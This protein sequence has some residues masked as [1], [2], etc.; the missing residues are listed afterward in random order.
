MSAIVPE[1]RICTLD[2]QLLQRNEFSMCLMVGIL[3]FFKFVFV[4]ERVTQHYVFTDLV[5]FFIPLLTVVYIFFSQ[6]YP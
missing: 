5:P 1:L 3:M 4:C 2:K 6:I